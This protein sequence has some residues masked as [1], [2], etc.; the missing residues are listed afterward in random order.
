VEDVWF[1]YPGAAEPA[2][3]G[4]SLRIRAG[5]LVALVGE[6]GAGKTTLARLLA[7]LYDPNHGRIVLDG[8]DLRDWPLEALRTAVAVA[9]QQPGGFEATAGENIAYGSWQTL[10]NDPAG[11]RA[12]ATES[13]ADEVVQ[14][15]PRGY[16]TALG[17]QFGEWD[18][19]P[20]QW[21]RLALSRPF[22]RRAPVLILDEPTVHLDARAAS[23]LAA[24]L[25]TL[26]FG[27]TTIMVTH[28]LALAA[29]A[30]RVVVLERGRLVEAGPH[31]ELLARGGAYAR[32]WSAAAGGRVVD[33][34]GAPPLTSGRGRA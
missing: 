15:L 1:T 27:R 6:N 2:L 3:A 19:S 28:G 23:A 5:E 7:R 10:L 8:M 4:V 16:D 25:R 34:A 9:P 21:Q 22:A 33:A 31:A 32:L 24:R 20:G 30:D 17:R 14:I 12:V 11:I 18:L 26:S 29:L 13:G